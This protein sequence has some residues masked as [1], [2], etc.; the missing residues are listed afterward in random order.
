MKAITTL[1]TMLFFSIT[2]HSALI[3][4]SQNWQTFETDNFRV[5]Y[6]EEYQHWALTSAVEM[7]N[8]RTLVKKQQNR[9]LT[10]KIDAYIVDPL[11]SSNGFVIPLSHHPSMVL[12]VTPP[13]SANMIF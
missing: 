5:H 12:F 6:T 9:A 4:E 8:I 11:N 3:D 2:S 7:E 1:L 10:E 13:Q